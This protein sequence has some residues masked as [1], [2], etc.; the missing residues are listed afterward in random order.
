MKGLYVIVDPEHCAGRDPSAV[1]EQALRGGTR[2]LQLRAKHLADAS[3]LALARDLRARCLAHGAAFWVNDRLDIALLSEADGLHLGQEDLP[4][5]EARKLAPRLKLGLSTHSLDQVRA[6]RAAGVTTIGFGPIFQTRSKERPSPTVG[7]EGLRAVC[8][9]H[10][11]LEVIAIGG[12]ALS[13]AAELAQAGAS[14]AAVISAVCGAADPEAA[15]RAL[16]TALG[17]QR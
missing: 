12:I 2:A 9:A 11:E 8:A 7:I 4:P 5:H 15:A 1:A 14:Y 10:P 6:A 3:L 13:H 17:A 16:S